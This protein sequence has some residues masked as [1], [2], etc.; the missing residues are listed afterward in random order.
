MPPPEALSVLVSV[1]VLPPVDVFAPH[2][3]MANARPVLAAMRAR[4]LLRI[5]PSLSRRCINVVAHNVCPHPR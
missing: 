3:V 5:Q 2:A 4:L 1:G